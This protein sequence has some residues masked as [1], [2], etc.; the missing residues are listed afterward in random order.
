MFFCH[1]VSIFHPENIRLYFRIPFCQ[2]IHSSVFALLGVMFKINTSVLQ[3]E[4]FFLSDI[5]LSIEFS[6]L[7]MKKS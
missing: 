6:A 1:N 3:E 5:S 7:H 2:S 4:K